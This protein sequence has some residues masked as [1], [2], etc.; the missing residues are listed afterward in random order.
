MLAQGGAV[1]QGLAN[2]APKTFRGERGSRLSFPSFSGHCSLS[3]VRP[4]RVVAAVMEFVPEQPSNEPKELANNIVN[5]C[6][7]TL[8]RSAKYMDSG[9]AYRALAHSV[10]ERLIRRFRETRENF[11]NEN[12]SRAY[13]L[14]MEFLMGR[15]LRNAILNI[16][17]GEEYKEA[18]NLLGYNLEDIVEEETDAALGN[19]GLGR[20]AACFLDSMATLNLPAYGY[21]IRYQYGMFKQA[22]VDGYQHES[23]DYWLT[24]GNPWDVERPH[25][26]YDINFYGY[27]ESFERNGR[28][29]FRWVPGEQV[30]AVA[31]DTLVPGWDTK[32]CIALRLWSAKPGKEFDLE[33]FNTG[34]YVNA[35]QNR[36]RAESISA[37]LYPDDRTYEGKELRLKQQFFMSSASLQDI[38]NRFVVGSHVEPTRRDKNTDDIDWDTLSDKVCIQLNDTHPTVSVAELMRLLMDEH[39]LGWTRAWEITKRCFAF[40]N[41]TVLPEALEK[42]DVELF[43]RLLPRHFDIIATINQKFRDELGQLGLPEGTINKMAIIGIDEYGPGKSTIRMA[44]L[45]L[46][47]SKAVNGVAALHT[48]IIKDTVFKEF[49]DIWPEKFFNMTNGVTPRRWLAFCNPKLKDLITSNLGSEAWV[50]DLDQLKKLRTSASQ[51]ALMKAWRDVKLGNKAKLAKLILRDTGIEIPLDAMYDIQVKRIH[52]Y[53]RQLLNVLYSIY[54]YKQIKAMSSEQ[55]K[56]VVKRVVIIGGKAAPGYEIAKKI[57]KL[58]CAVGERVNNDPDVGD[59]L[60]VVFIPNYNV[61][62]AETI[63]PA[64]E[65]TQQISTAGTEASGTGNMK[66]A[67]NGGLII[68]TMDGANIEIWEEIGEENGFVFGAR[69]PEVNGIRERAMN[70][71]IQWDSRFYEALDMIKQGHF[72]ETDYF[73]SL[74][75]NVGNPANDYYI[76]GYDF[77]LYIDAQK[78]VD[79]TYK[80]QDKWT[81]MSIMSTAGMGKFSTDRTIRD[82]ATKIWGVKSIKLSQ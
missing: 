50:G 29:L 60:K 19:G 75:D 62:A 24:F 51:P 67:M 58:I 48:Q 32:N 23:P 69:T 22:I 77:P 37:V 43:R 65:L 49:H 81:T 4:R 61:S 41:H 57:I 39:E 21:G 70:G 3:R 6:E 36:Q 40:T 68:G 47:G 5:H 33:S 14:S 13:Y 80:N 76:C 31:Y 59:L 63:M 9:S 73:Q 56:D 30:I 72:G 26:T 18:L 71:Q 27:V 66:F 25:V 20:L 1:G 45:A 46:V 38:L 11:E 12:P 44:H 64:A 8:A 53:K 35:I 28:G 78:R 7:Y 79:E 54:R 42:W 17:L 52:E 2:L 10:S 55:K 16:D 34:D 15:S 82:Y 74:V